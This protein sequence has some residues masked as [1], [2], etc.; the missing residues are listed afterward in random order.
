MAV[1]SSSTSQQTEEAVDYLKLS[2]TMVHCFL[3][4]LFA[5]ALL[6]PV[7]GTTAAPPPTDREDGDAQ[8]SVGMELPVASV[9]A[10]PSNGFTSDGIDITLDEI[11]AQVAASQP[12]QEDNQHQEEQR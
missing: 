2:S 9:E 12:I 3:A 7:P 11:V 1:V 8:G 4:L 10:I 6:C 5:A